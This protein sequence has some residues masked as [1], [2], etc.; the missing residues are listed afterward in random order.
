MS[1][2]T[3]VEVSGSGDSVGMRNFETCVDAPGSSGRESRGSLKRDTSA[4]GEHSTLSVRVPKRSRPHAPDD[5]VQPTRLFG[6]SPGTKRALSEL[7][8]NNLLRLNVSPMDTSPSGDRQ[9]SDLATT[10]PGENGAGMSLIG[11][12]AADGTESPRE[13]EDRD[14]SESAA[15][16]TPPSAKVRGFELSSMLD[17][18]GHDQSA[19]QPRGAG[20]PGPDTILHRQRKSMLS[21]ELSGALLASASSIPAALPAPAPVL[22]SPSRLLGTL[23][24]M[25]NSAV[26]PPS[27]PS[28]EPTPKGD[29]RKQAIL[30][31][32]SL[33]NPVGEGM[34]A[35]SRFVSPG[36]ASPKLMLP[37]PLRKERD[38]SD[39]ED[40]DFNM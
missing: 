13:K 18:A 26:L 10:P 19:P 11:G 30:R 4:S 29:L 20:T 17:D 38:V 28:A 27:S 36:V 3:G 37:A 2:D 8:A 5:D 14:A 24:M 25:D 31:R 22:P 15:A 16:T 39:D 33:A 35:F 12:L 7:M 34:T 6:A 23:S 40:D 9:T 21:Q 32:V 1:C